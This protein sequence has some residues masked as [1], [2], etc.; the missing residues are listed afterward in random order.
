MQDSPS[1][2][3]RQLHPQVEERFV[4]GA[5]EAARFFVSTSNIHAALER[6]VDRLTELEIPYA[7]VGALTL[8]AYGY[9]RT[10]TDVDV[11]VR[12][13]GLDAFKKAHLGRGYVERFPG[14]KAPG[15][16][17]ELPSAQR[18]A[19]WSRRA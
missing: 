8:N 2:A 10:T 7:I 4:R 12:R 3:G 16:Q 9:Q 17:Q 18:T 5:R 13:D 1:L 19:D 6:P 15:A 11:L 14:S